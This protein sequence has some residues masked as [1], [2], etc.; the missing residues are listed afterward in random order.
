ME[1]EQEQYEEKEAMMAWNINAEYN[2]TIFELLHKAQ[3]YFS[4]GNMGRHFHTLNVAYESVSFKLEAEVLKDFDK[5]IALILNRRK[6]WDMYQR[7]KDYGESP[8]GIT[9]REMH[10]G[11]NEFSKLTVAFQ[12]KLLSLLKEIGILS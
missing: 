9:M 7:I 10:K 8:S 12:R 3:M 6:Y 2:K 11:R 4:V 5:H 1:Q